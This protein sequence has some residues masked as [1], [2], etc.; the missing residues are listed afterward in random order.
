MPINHAT[1]PALVQAKAKIIGINKQPKIDTIPKLELMAILIGANIANYCIDA[2]FSI[3]IETLYLWSDSRTA[4]SWCSSYDIKE[5]FVSNRV[6]QIRKLAPKA[7]LK[8]LESA[9]NPADIL[10]RQP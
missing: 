7:K 9:N 2:L 4:L 1:K 5:E 8:Y 6:R 3:E 10:T